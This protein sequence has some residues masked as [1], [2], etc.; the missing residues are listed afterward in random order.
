MTPIGR[1]EP[2]RAR[3]H[4]ILICG[5]LVHVTVT[6]RRRVGCVIIRTHHE[7]EI[8]SSMLLGMRSQNCESVQYRLRHALATSVGRGKSCERHF[9]VK[10]P[11]VFGAGGRKE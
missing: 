8:V 11:I 4:R 1:H 3:H 10:S 5:V 2:I 7:R 6:T 9:L